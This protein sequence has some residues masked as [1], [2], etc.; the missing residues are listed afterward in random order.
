MYRRAAGGWY[1]AP[2]GGGGQAAPTAVAPNVDVQAVRGHPWASVGVLLSPH[3]VDEPQAGVPRASGV[4]E[5]DQGIAPPWVVGG[6]LFAAAVVDLLIGV[7]F[8][9]FP[10]GWW[11]PVVVVGEEV[12]RPV[13]PV[14]RRRVWHRQAAHVAVPQLG[15]AQ[16]DDVAWGGL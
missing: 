10:H 12:V 6:L 1:V 15:G 8:E 16:R 2:C 13:V 7:L 9:A 11:P 4:E 3:G 14:P 5:V